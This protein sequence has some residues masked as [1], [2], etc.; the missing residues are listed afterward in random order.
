MQTVRIQPE[1]FDTGSIIEE[2]KQA[3]SNTGAI[4][5]F[6]GCVR[7]FASDHVVRA[8]TLEHYPGMTEKIL[9]GIADKATDRWNLLGCT[10]IHRVGKLNAGENIVFVATASLHRKAAFEAAQFIMDFLKTE[11]PFWKKEHTDKGDYWVESKTSDQQEK[12]RWD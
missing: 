8:I 10:V 3:C 11:A 9:H 4:V 12:D 2:L 5:S 1:D 7:E 6:T